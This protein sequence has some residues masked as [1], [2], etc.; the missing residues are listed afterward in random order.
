M[1]ED[2]TNITAEEYVKYLHI[3]I[4]H[5]EDMDQRTEMIQHLCE[6]RDQLAHLETC[7]SLP[8]YAPNRSV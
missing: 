7:Y 2:Y 4:S 8:S 3:A 6:V 1:E 5:V